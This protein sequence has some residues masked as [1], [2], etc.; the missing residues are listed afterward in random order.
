MQVNE[1]PANW[2]VAG[3]SVLLTLVNIDPIH[4]R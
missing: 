2:A 1:E 4:L 3:D